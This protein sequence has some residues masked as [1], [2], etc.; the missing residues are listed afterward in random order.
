VDEVNGMNKETFDTLVEIKVALANL[1]GKVDQLTD[2]KHTV[3]ITRQT[4]NEADNR[5]KQ[6][7]KDIKDI[8][9]SES[10][11]W[12]A[13]LTLGGTFLLE[14]IYFLLTYGFGK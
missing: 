7:E 6:N 4:A 13:I 9:S 1:S 10:K 3:E 8:K 14:L 2:M 12:G 11:K 5:S